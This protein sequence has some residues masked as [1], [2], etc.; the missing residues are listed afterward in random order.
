MIAKRR[1]EHGRGL[2]KYRWVFERKHA[3]LRSFRRLSICIERHAEVHE[4]FLKL[5]CCLVCWNTLNR[6]QSL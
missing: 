1:S 2:G 3:W 4:A 6:E 5:G